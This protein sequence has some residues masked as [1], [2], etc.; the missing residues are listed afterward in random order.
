MKTNT[1]KQTAQVEVIPSYE[2][3]ALTVHDEHVVV[4]QYCRLGWHQGKE[5]ILLVEKI[6]ATNGTLLPKEECDALDHNGTV[7]PRWQS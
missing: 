6:E 4:V 7:R 5:R 1:D 2:H 3:I